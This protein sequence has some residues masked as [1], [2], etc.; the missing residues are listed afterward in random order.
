MIKWYVQ[1]MLDA[2]TSNFGTNVRKISYSLNVVYPIDEGSDLSDGKV[3][4]RIRP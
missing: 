3:A 1:E 4:I 2:E